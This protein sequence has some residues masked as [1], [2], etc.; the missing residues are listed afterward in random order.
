M[1]LIR[2]VATAVPP[3]RVDQSEA[4]QFAQALFQSKHHDIDRLLGV[5]DSSGIESRYFSM[6]IDWFAQ[7]R[8]FVEKNAEYIRSATELSRRAVESVL[9][10]TGCKA[11][12]IDYLIYINTTGLATPSI[13][14]RLIN[15]LGLRSDIRRTPIWG[16][17]CAGGAAGLSHA[18]HYLLAHPDHQ[19]MVVAAELCGLTF[20]PN[21]FS[22]SNLVAAA[23]FGEGAAAVLIS[24]NSD[25][26]TGP[27]TQE[28][29]SVFYPDS[30]DV[31][32]W[33]MVESGLQVIFAQRI[34]DIVRERA[35]DDLQAF[36]GAQG[37]SI[38]DINAFLFHPGGRKVI[39]AYEEALQLPDGALDCCREVL[40][41]YGNMSSVTILFV[42]ERFL[43]EYYQPS[44]T[45]RHALLS[46]LG[47]GFSSESLLVKY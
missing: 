5:F 13:D 29:H 45:K 35:A 26:A 43:R 8:S 9:Q 6:P 15:L 28:T 47:P 32:G 34:P 40:R 33:N 27:R 25:T 20:I 18:H 24:G 11:D 36:L 38:A 14:A 2:G 37:L 31:M 22:R 3:Y 10:K 30:L 1:P 12:D 46:A 16:L 39:E 7:P 21:D 4:R 41:D 44:Q 23:L 19:V 42:L 17:G